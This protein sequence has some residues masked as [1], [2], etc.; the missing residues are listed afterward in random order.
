[1]KLSEIAKIVGGELRGDPDTEIN[2]ISPSDEA[3]TGSLCFAEKS[4]FLSNLA[5]SGVSAVLLTS[6]LATEFEGNCVIVEQPRESLA[7]LLPYFSKEPKPS[8]GI[9]PTAFIE[10]SADVSDSATIGPHCYVGHNSKIGDR[11]VLMGGVNVSTDSVIGQDSK[12]FPNVT[13][14]H[15]CRIGDRVRI[16]SGTVIGSDGFG[17]VMHQGEHQKIH[18]IGDVEIQDDVEIGAGCT[19]DRGALGTTKICKGSKLDN[20]VQV[21]HNVVVGEHSILVAQVGVAG[22]TKM[23]KYVVIAGQAGVSGHLKIGDQVTIG[24]NSG[25][26]KNLPSGATVMGYPA[27]DHMNFKRSSVIFQKLPGILKKLKIK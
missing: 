3:Q 19:I 12:V 9:H 24:G 27:I 18:Q 5:N 14:Y 1:M 8:A 25:V 2:K 11:T 20:L 17:Y 26:T 13:I 10:D 22:S 7:R 21:A 16:H 6:E 15:G 4:N 23:G